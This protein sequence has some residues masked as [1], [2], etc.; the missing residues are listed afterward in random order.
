[1]KKIESD[2]V[3]LNCSGKTSILH[4]NNIAGMEY[5]EIKDGKTKIRIFLI[6]P[7]VIPNEGKCNSFWVDISESECK[8]IIEWFDNY[9]LTL[10]EKFKIAIFGKGAI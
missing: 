2:V 10:W 7:L 1:M 8:G 6:N 9:E 4:R 3:L 5:P